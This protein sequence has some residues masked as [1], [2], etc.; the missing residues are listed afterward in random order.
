MGFVGVEPKG[1]RDWWTP[2]KGLRDTRG[3]LTAA[4]EVAATCNEYIPEVDGKADPHFGNWSFRLLPD[5]SCTMR[6][7]PPSMPP[8]RKSNV[9]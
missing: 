2:P 6:P 3:W 4:K 7:P 1:W 5:N 9:D 8:P